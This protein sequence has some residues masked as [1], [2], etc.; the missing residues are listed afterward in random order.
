MAATVGTVSA[1]DPQE[2]SLTYRLTVQ[3]SD[4]TNSAASSVDVTVTDVNDV[5]VFSQ[6]TYAFS[7][8]ETAKPWFFL[9]NVSATDLDEG[10]SILYH[11]GLRLTKPLPFVNKVLISRPKGALC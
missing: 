10:D 11:V 9:G 3:A 4:G 6:D 8:G 2:D 5:P 1:T 7:I